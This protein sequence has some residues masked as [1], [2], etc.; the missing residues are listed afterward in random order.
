MQRKCPQVLNDCTLA[1]PKIDRT[2]KW[3]QFKLAI[4][5]VI[6]TEAFPFRLFCTLF[7]TEVVDTFNLHV[8]HNKDPKL[9]FE[10]AIRRLSLAMIYN[11]LD[12]I[13]AGDWTGD[14]P[15]D[16]P[17]QVQQQQISGQDQPAGAE[18]FLNSHFLIPFA[19]LPGYRGYKQQRCVYS[20]KATTW[21]CITCTV[22][23]YIIFPLHPT[24]LAEHQRNP[25][26]KQCV[27]V[28]KKKREER[29]SSEPPTSS[30][31][32]RTQSRTD[33]GE[34]GEESEEG[35]EEEGEE[36]SE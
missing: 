28:G 12:E 26:E 9:E 34:D 35:E 13:D 14:V 20:N 21:T 7:G 30:S 19:C 23:N 2:N 31:R 24:K 4:E 5:R 3:R 10:T 33:D 15:Y 32:P 8:Y 11:K 6:R 18:N 16:I 17:A 1:Q 29:R 22:S 36:E 27:T 25:S